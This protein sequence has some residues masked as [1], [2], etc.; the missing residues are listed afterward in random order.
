MKD[1]TTALNSKT[2]KDVESIVTGQT[3]QVQTGPSFSDEEESSATSKKLSQLLKVEVEVKR[4]PKS[5]SKSELSDESV[6]NEARPSGLQKS[7][8]VVVLGTSDIAGGVDQ[9]TSCAS[10]KS[11]S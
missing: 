6:E 2:T 3:L 9:K 5:I 8:S 1:K 4:K 7:L 11:P 10:E